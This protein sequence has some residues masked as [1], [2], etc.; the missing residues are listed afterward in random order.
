MPRGGSG[1]V[2][3]G[4]LACGPGGG[5][6]GGGGV[7]GGSGAQLPG[8]GAPGAGGGG[9]HGG[10][11]VV[12]LPGALSLHQTGPADDAGPGGGQRSPGPD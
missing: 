5:G 8:D 7:V 1:R 6:G 11:L 3:S 9:L 2:S 10:G 12:V 4:G